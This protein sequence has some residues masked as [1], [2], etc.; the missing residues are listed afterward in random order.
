MVA[1]TSLPPSWTVDQYLA[2]ERFSEVRHEYIDGVVYA[3]AG[4]TGAHSRLAA[5]LISLLVVALRDGA[6][7]VYSSDMKVRIAA[8]RYVYPDVS[9]GCAGVERNEFGDEWMTTPRLVAEVL[10]KTTAAY[11][12]GSKFDLYRSTGTLRDYV[13]VEA[14]RRLVEVRHR[15]ADGAWTTRTYGPGEWVDL[16]GLAVRLAVDDL[17]AKVDLDEPD[18][19]P[20]PIPAGV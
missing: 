16:S 18:S 2:L 19:G 15:G 5:N 7:G 13:L 9:V 3:L 12:R 6:C 10:S 4:G 8:T 20:T 14:T 11:D 17:Y 1:L